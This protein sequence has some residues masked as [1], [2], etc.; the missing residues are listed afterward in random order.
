MKYKN[1]KWVEYG[2]TW[3][4]FVNEM[5]EMLGMVVY[6]DNREYLIGNINR[7]NGA[8]GCCHGIWPDDIVIR[9]AIAVEVENK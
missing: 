4:Y 6:V 2:K 8:C 7:S 5:D 9:Y 3:R 1:L